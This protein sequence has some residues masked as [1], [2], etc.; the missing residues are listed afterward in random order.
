MSYPEPDAYPSASGVIRAATTAAVWSMVV[1]VALIWAHDLEHH[2]KASAIMT[3]LEQR[4]ELL[5][6]L[7]N[8]LISRDW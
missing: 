5:E 1:V 8:Q 6:R 7:T 2:E 4:V 3:Q